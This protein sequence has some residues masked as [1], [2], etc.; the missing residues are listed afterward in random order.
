[1]K[2]QHI[3]SA[4]LVFSVMACKGTGDVTNPKLTPAGP[5]PEVNAESKAL[6]QPKLR[7][8]SKPGPSVKV[9][10]NKGPAWIRQSIMETDDLFVGVGTSQNTNQSIAREGAMDQARATLSKYKSVQIKS[11]S[12]QYS[13]LVSDNE[14]QTLFQQARNFINVES[15][16]QLR[17][18]TVFGEPYIEKFDGE[19]IYYVRV[20]IPKEKLL[21]EQKIRNI[22]GAK[23]GSRKRID[24]LLELANSFAADGMLANAEEA[25]K[26]MAT[27][28]GTK[29]EDVLQVVRFLYNKRQDFE[30]ANRY[31]LSIRKEI[32]AVPASDPTRKSW[33]RLNSML[34]SR[35]PTV[36]ESIN[37]IKNYTANGKDSKRF[38][39]SIAQS[40]RNPAGNTDVSISLNVSGPSRR[41]LVL[42]IDHEDFSILP[43]AGE[44]KTIS[45]NHSI[46]FALPKGSKSVDLLFWSLP[47]NSSVWAIVKLLKNKSVSRKKKVSGSDSMRLWSLRERLRKALDNSASAPAAASALRITP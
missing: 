44:D 5:E 26:C 41:I 42:W 36:S 24:L 20:A 35:I 40:Q 29:T 31:L 37:D 23:T 17:F 10:G 12:K 46:E 21:P 15:S 34:T 8:L 11:I 25:Y 47:S 45:G 22:F 18:T 4:A 43:Y 28:T 1:M 14:S 9:I 39:V 19:F 38:H 32:L 33:E 6:V 13:E 7:P 3:L 2:L 16:G 30:E 27:L